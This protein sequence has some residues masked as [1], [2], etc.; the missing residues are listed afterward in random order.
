[1][2]DTITVAD[3]ELQLPNGL[4]PSAF[5]LPAGS[6]ACPVSLSLQLNLH[7]S[8]VPTSVSS[9]TMSA[10]SVN[11]FSVSQ[12]VYHLLIDDRERLWTGPRE[13]G[14]AVAQAVLDTVQGVQS[15]CLTVAL[16]K[17][18]LHAQAAVYALSY[19]R[20]G[21]EDAKATIKG[22]K[23]PTVIGLLDHERLERQWLDF[24]L[25]ARFDTLFESWDHK[26]FADYAR[27]V[28]CPVETADG[29]TSSNPRL[30]R[31]KLCCITLPIISSSMDLSNPLKPLLLRSE[32]HLH[33]RTPF[34]SSPSLVPLPTIPHRFRPP[35]VRSRR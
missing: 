12:M 19:S 23:V 15:L 18:L 3:L 13:L 27:E 28:S 32:S 6:V 8:C 14:D 9:D 21:L 7:P 22:L 2:S 20:S 31:W 17:A 5:G 10:L 26:A 35:T 33:S 29:S 11:Y 16:P 30:A 1:M 25:T 24:D 34:P 4:G